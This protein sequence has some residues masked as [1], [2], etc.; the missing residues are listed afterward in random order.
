MW[1]ASRAQAELPKPIVVHV[2]APHAQMPEE[3]LGLTFEDL[4]LKRR[5]GSHFILFAS[6]LYSFLYLFISY[7]FILR[8]SFSV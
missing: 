4:D 8:Q 3:L 5:F 2:K 1:V 6:F 7:L